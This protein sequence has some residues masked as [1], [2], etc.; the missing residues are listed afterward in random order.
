MP[1][2]FTNFA[3]T[4]LASGITDI[5]TTLAVTTGDGDLFPVADLSGTGDYFDIVIEDGATPPNIEILQVTDRTLGSDNLTV[6]RAQEGTT[7]FAFAANSRVE[8]R[9]TAATMDSY[10]TGDGDTISGN[11]N[12][13]I[14]RNTQLP[15]STGNPALLKQGELFVNLNGQDLYSA[16]FDDSSPILLGGNNVVST[17]APGEPALGKLWFDSNNSI[18]N[19]WN[20]LAWVDVTTGGNPPSLGEEIAQGYN[21][22]DNAEFKVWQRPVFTDKTAIATDTPYHISGLWEY[23]HSSYQHFDVVKLEDAGVTGAKF[24]TDH[25]YRFWHQ[26]TAKAGPGASEWAGLTQK[27]EGH[28][29]LSFLGGTRTISLWLRSLLA[30]DVAICLKTATKS[31]VTSVNIAAGELNTWVKKTVDVDMSTLSA[32]D[33]DT[34]NGFGFSFGI[35]AAA[36]ANY[37]P[38]ATDQWVTGDYRSFSGAFSLALLGDSVLDVTQIKMSNVTTDSVFIPQPYHIDKAACERRYFSTFDDDVTPADNTADWSGAIMAPIA[39]F[40]GTSRMLPIATQWFPTAMRDTP[41]IDLYSVTTAT[42]DKWCTYEAGGAFPN[43]SMTISAEVQS[44][45]P[46]YRGVVVK[47]TGNPSNSGQMSVM[48]IHLVATSYL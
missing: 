48:G 43:P 34:G 4:L 18:L 11:D 3:S 22:L 41:T 9:P 47:S 30:G 36:G 45:G 16:L 33:I 28:R 19:I 7:A 35:M 40:S 10:L 26:G 23:E 20:G 24:P 15:P 46:T 32:S 14:T 29:A 39:D 12:T 2:L 21:A 37:F 25:A 42:T 5:Q 38:P 8:L 1:R 31:Y 27:I 13:L 17:S 44:E 6:V